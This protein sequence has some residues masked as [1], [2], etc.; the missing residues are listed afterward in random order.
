VIQ[1]PIGSGKHTFIASLVET[2][3]A[4][5]VTVHLDEQ[6]DINSLLGTY[7]VN[8]S[9]IV[10]KKGPLSIAAEKGWWILLKNVDKASDILSGVHID[11]GYLHVLSGK[12]IKCQPG[13]RV[14]ATCYEDLDSHDW[15]VVNLNDLQKD[16]ILRICQINYRNIWT[17][18][19]LVDKILGSI[20]TLVKSDL[21]RHL[22]DKKSVYVHDVMRVIRRVNNILER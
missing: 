12:K 18:E 8:E 20:E 1:G 17:S 21:N 19:G 22:L 5:L 7:Y 15:E 4:H 3:N 16:D 13:F 2:F 6:T 9:D 10:Y 14:I 11:G